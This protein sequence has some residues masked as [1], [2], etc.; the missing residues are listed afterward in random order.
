MLPKTHIIINLIISL[1]LLI[2]VE[3][4]YVLIFFLSS[5]LIDVDHYLY[6][7]YEKKNFSLKKAYNWNKKSIKQF[8]N[9]SREEKKR[10]RYFV[11]LLH[12]IETLIIILILSRFFP[13]LFYVFLGFLT[14]LIEDA[15]VSIKFKYLERRLSIIYAT[16]LHQK[17]KVK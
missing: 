4:L 17:Y 10:H 3:P 8:H 1:V 14:H 12:G 5:I 9:L 15:F 2:G 7:I 11:F 16:Y 13:I 6:Y